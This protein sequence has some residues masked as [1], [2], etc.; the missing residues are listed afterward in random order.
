MTRSYLE[1]ILDTNP[2]RVPTLTSAVRELELPKSSRGLDVGCGAGLQCLLLA[3]EVGN[4]GHVTGLDVSAEFLS[5]AEEM[6]ERAYLAKRI[7][8]KKGDAASIP[9]DDGTFDW[10]WSCD[11]V[12]YGPGEP[13]PLLEEMKRV[14]RPGG[15]LAIL[16]WSSERLLPGHPLLEARL[17]A[18][19][20][21]LAPF[22]AGMDPS[23]H[24]S[25]GLGWLRE[26]GF[27]EPTAR[28]FSGSVQAPLSDELRI[29]MEELFEMRW[30]GAEKELPES[31]AADFRRL[32]DPDSPDFILRHPDYYAF[33]TYTVFSGMV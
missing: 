23:R 30:P 16:A 32:C 27:G 26:L 31:D 20:A 28:V 22:S 8:F 19:V 6:V 11:C 33:F 5:Y 12:G 25:R 24:F 4:E 9:F 14:T 21:G 1:K 2:L 18:T 29:A 17:N 10:V 7:S 13:I 3:E 15:L